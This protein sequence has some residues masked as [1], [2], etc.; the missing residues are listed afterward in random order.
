MREKGMIINKLN[1]TLAFSRA[2]FEIPRLNG[3]LMINS[4]VYMYKNYNENV[5]YS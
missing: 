1:K 2:T 4:R 5:C 3:T